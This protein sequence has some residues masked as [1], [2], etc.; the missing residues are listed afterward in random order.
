MS[1]A[2]ERLSHREL[3]VEILP[4]S[5]ARISAFWSETG[6]VRNDW[7]TPAP[8][9][10]ASSSA[11]GSFP[12]VPFS[13]RIR[14]GRFS[15]NGQEHRLAVSGQHAPHAIHGH[16]RNRPWT[17]EHRTD[18]GIVLSYIHTG[19]DWPFAYKACQHIAIDG[20]ALVIGMALENI[21]DESM[22]GGLGH[23][24][25]LPWRS[26][27]VLSTG[28]GNVWPATDGVL[29]SGPET[30]P[31]TLD[32]TLGRAL[33]RGLDTGFGGWS[34]RAGIHWPGEGLAL[35]IDCSAALGHVIIFTP[36]GADFFC[37]EPVTHA[38]DALNLSARG[39][40]ETGQISVAPGESLEVSMRFSPRVTAG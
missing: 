24:P 1:G 33:P 36:P 15:W 16:G 32:F 23:H 29:P 7:F 30:L 21:G 19:G 5:G 22:P 39:V 11:W 17:V 38:I 27:P 18:A 37:F 9:D 8:A 12:L 20:D 2:V 3:N 26:G 34:G 28:F 40:P 6:G 35:D 14:D 10:P 13:N 31:E 4:E 25:Y